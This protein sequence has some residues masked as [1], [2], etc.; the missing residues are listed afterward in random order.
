MN[1]FQAWLDDADMPEMKDGKWYDLETGLPYDPSFDY[2]TGVRRTQLSPK[3]L[4]A[5]A[6]AKQFGGKAL[7]GSAK[8]KEWAEKIRAEKLVEMDQDQAEMACDPNGLLTNSKFWIEN[9]SA[10]GKSIGEFVMNQKAML[11]QHK[12]ASKAHRFDDM[13]AIAENYNALTAKWGF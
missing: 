11:A 2:K 12:V 7:K 6:M 8:Q 1:N 4:D 13:K 5:R 10:S 3:A 9:R